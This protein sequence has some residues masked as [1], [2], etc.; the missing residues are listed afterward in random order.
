M[1]DE[2]IIFDKKENFDIKLKHIVDDDFI[3]QIKLDKCYI[4]FKSYNQYIGIFYKNNI[5]IFNLEDGNDAI[6]QEIASKIKDLKPEFAEYLK[7]LHSSDLQLLKLLKIKNK[8]KNKIQKTNEDF[9]FITDLN[10]IDF[11]NLDKATNTIEKLNLKLHKYCSNKEKNT[12]SLNT[13]FNIENTNFILKEFDTSKI[14]T[15]VGSNLPNQLL[16][17]YFNKN[18]CI[19]QIQLNIVNNDSIY[20]TVLTIDSDTKTGYEGL[21][22]NRLLRAISIIIAKE[23][24][25]KI[26][27]IMSNAVNP[28]SLYLLAK[29]YN[30]KVYNSDTN[31]LEK[32]FNSQTTYTQAN[33]YIKRY[34]GAMVYVELTQENISNAEILF[35]DLTINSKDSKI[36]CISEDLVDDTD[37]ILTE[38]S[39]NGLEKKLKELTLQELGGGYVKINTQ[40]SIKK[41]T[42]KKKIT[43]KKRK[44]QKITKKKRK[45]QK[46]TKKK[47]KK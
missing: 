2:L 43:K 16:L 23:I 21:K 26:Q 10:C 36:T 42:K 27:A 12:I 44:K 9:E 28:I 32:E 11:V 38:N 14:N 17:C 37:I 25:N 8:I 33:E 3:F 22:I 47:A 30:A 40:K 24:N 15:A 39:D 1:V 31:N 35:D 7:L 46:I 13:V 34:G 45:K 20:G 4:Y 29:Y 19:S 41:K 6:P 18:N 5:Y